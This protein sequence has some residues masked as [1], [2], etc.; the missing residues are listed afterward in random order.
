[1]RYICLRDDDTNFNTDIKE[2]KGAYGRYWGKY[3]ITLATVPFVHGS[4][5]KIKDFDLK[6]DKFA[7]LRK[8]EI[9]ASR[10]ELDDYY[11]IYPIGKN[12]GLLYELKKQIDSNKIEIALHG[13]NHKY[14]E[15]GAEMYSD[16]ISYY[17]IREG[18]EY[19]EKCFDIT[20]KTFIPP[21]NT[22]DL[23]CAKYV[24]ELGM[25]LLSS[26]TP[27][28]SSKFEKIISCIIDPSPFIEKISGKRRNMPIKTR[29]HIS[30]F[31]SYTFGVQSDPD[32]FLK[33]VISDLDKYKFAAIG[34]HYW[35]LNN[36]PTKKDQYHRIIEALS[37]S[38][39]SFVT[40]DEYYSKMKGFR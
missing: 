22:I 2:L 16:S 27:K 26:G 6:S 29:R 15:R 30:V 13:Y 23:T 12:I 1:M 37:E 32:A 36:N 5:Q 17:D 38:D 28:G 3:P 39:V 11:S 18:K 24:N 34:T 9:S 21:S 19:L 35:F 40:A 14:N 20:V 7:Q 25:N 33:K 31:S 4:E 8:W 10:E